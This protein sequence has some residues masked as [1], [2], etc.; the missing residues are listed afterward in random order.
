MY[1]ARARSPPIPPARGRSSAD[2]YHRVVLDALAIVQ[3]RMSSTRFPGKSVAEVGGEP[4]L[5]LLV[6]RLQRARE[7]DRIVVATSVDPA[8]DRVQE[9]A[10][11]V[12]VHVHRGSLE[13]VLSRF[14]GAAK[15][16]A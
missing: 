16:H 2:T 11:Q 9:V 8:D 10:A 14:V 15:G 7:L 3:A 6:R 5:A 1:P 13:D 4:M 12:G